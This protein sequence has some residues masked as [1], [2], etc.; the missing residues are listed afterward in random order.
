MEP[1]EG[2]QT[3]GKFFALFPGSLDPKEYEKGKRITVGGKIEGQERIASG[4]QTEA[5]PVIRAMDSRLWD[6]CG[7][8]HYAY[9]FYKDYY[10]GTKS[11]YH[12]AHNYNYRCQ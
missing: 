1:R 3:G 5:Y 4:Q 10:G 8:G 12:K 11:P 6:S 7:D 9:S 2:D